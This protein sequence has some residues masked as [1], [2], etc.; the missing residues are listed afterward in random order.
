VWVSAHQCFAHPV[1]VEPNNPAWKGHTDGSVWMCTLIDDTTPIVV[2]WVPPGGPAGGPVDPG[3]L[4]RSALGVLALAR[5][6]V[7][8][9]PAYPD[10]SIVGVRNWLW[11]PEAQWRPL[12]KTVRAGATAVS[13]TATPS[14][15]VWDMGPDETSCDNAGRV[16]RDGMGDSA[17]TRCGYTYEQTSED[18]R[19]GVF[20]VTATIDYEVDWTCTGVCTTDSG[21]LGT[22]A[23]P[24]GTG[25]MRVLQSQTVVLR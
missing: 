12:R 18:E 24:V 11:V 8:T 1:D 4:A 14:R 7:E 16:W 15:V 17:V 25:T 19:G 23:A 9:A 5:A 22:V 13:V 21:S 2:F 10:P 20:D 6:R 3:V